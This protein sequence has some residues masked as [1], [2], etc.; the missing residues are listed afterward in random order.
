MSKSFVLY[1]DLIHT[2]KRLPEDKAGKLF[3]KI[4]S[5][6]N[7]EDIIDDDIVVDIAFEPIKQQL[8]RDLQKWKSVREKRR[9]AGSKGGKKSGISR[10]SEANEANASFVKQNEANE[11][12]NTNTNITTTIT[13]NKEDKKTKAKKAMEE[14]L[15]EE[16]KK[17]EAR[18]KEEIKIPD[19]INSEN[20]NEWMK[21]RKKK[22]FSS[23]PLAIKKII[24]ALNRFEEKGYSHDQINQSL[25][26]SMVANYGEVYE[27][28]AKSANNSK[29]GVK[30]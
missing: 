19:W 22:K 28:K 21:G 27:P 18:L 9:I 1:N 7:D 14:M 8:F 10:N 20:W 3:L 29:Y 12:I 5:C 17:A 26:K 24:N 11:A 23:S 2:V 30:F 16:S 4:L 25:E 6:V 13:S 15:S